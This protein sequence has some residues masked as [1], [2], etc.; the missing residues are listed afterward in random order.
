M[1][2][3]MVVFLASQPIY[4]QYHLGEVHL[5]ATILCDLYRNLTANV[6]GM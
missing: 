5:N 3:S 6:K 2:T 4:A 1:C